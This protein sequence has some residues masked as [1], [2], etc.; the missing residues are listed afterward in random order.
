MIR[1]KKWSTLYKGF[2]VIQVIGYYRA[3]AYANPEFSNKSL[4]DLKKQINK[5]L[6]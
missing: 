2:T 5:Y 3:S 6:K 1:D 4:S